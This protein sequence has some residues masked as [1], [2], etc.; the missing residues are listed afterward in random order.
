MARK[1]I[2]TAALIGAALSKKNHPNVPITP[3]EMAEA[4]YECYNEGAAIVHIH[5]RD[6]K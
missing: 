2:I 3:E 4:A 1:L 6:E 5:G